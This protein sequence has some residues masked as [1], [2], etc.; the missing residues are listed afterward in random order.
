VPTPT[1]WGSVVSRKS[2]VE[3]YHYATLTKTVGDK[4]SPLRQYLERRF[5]NTSAFRSEYRARSWDLMAEGGDVKTSGTVGT[6]FD[7]MVRLRLDS[8]YLPH[9]PRRG[10]IGATY[11][12][13]VLEVIDIA[14]AALRAGSD[15]TFIRACWALALCSELYRAPTVF[16]RSPLWLVHTSGNF[17]DI[18]LLGLA[19]DAAIQDLR[20]LQKVA[21][22]RLFPYIRPPYVLGPSFDASE[23]CPA[24]ADLIA[25]G[26]LIDI[27]TQVGTKNTQ[28]VRTDNLKNEHLYQ[29]VSY[30]LFDRSDTYRITSFGIY[31]A[32]YGCLTQ[33]PVSTGLETLAGER[34]DLT[35]ERQFVWRLLGGRR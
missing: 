28:G 24:D 2:P 34:I 25:D 30:L 35:A 16:R 12:G 29:V 11:P 22:E 17:T 18:E 23:L 5:P 14:R 33:W 10:V 21:D 13:V 31:S 20:N 27:K 4:A 3:K 9:E 8:S 32:R 7:L 1:H 6:A 26:S 15:D 19:P